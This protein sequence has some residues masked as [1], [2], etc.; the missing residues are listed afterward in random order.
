GALI[1]KPAQDTFYGGYA[2]YF[3]DP[4]GHIWEVVYNPGLAD[5]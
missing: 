1:F 5:T 3:K 2:G 4:D